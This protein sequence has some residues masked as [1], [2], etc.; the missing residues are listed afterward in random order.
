MV[1]ASQPPLQIV[2]ALDILVRTDGIRQTMQEPRSCGH[3]RCGLT[4]YRVPQNSPRSNPA[5]Q[6]PFA[7]VWDVYHGLQVKLFMITVAARDRVTPRD[8]DQGGL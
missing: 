8:T 7:K 5:P 3:H 2:V 6:S 1:R 4:D